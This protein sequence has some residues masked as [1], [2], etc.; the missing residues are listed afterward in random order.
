MRFIKNYLIGAGLPLLVILLYK[1]SLPVS[2]DLFSRN[3]LVQL[4]DWNRY[5]YILQSMFQVIASLGAWPLVS[6]PVVL[7]IYAMLA[8]FD[9]SDP[10][11]LKFVGLALLGQLA[12]YF[13]IY[14][15]TPG[16]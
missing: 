10:V 16:I 11:I 3:D 13:V 14:L 1:F 8:W 4:L 7:F 5:V 12:G 9:C 15:L 2:N 6:L